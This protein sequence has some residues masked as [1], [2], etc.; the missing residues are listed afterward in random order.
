[1]KKSLNAF[2]LIFILLFLT[3]CTVEGNKHQSPPPHENEKVQTNGSAQS[4][5]TDYE[6]EENEPMDSPSKRYVL[7]YPNI[8][9]M[10]LSQFDLQ[11][12]YVAD[13]RQRAEDDFTE[14][15]NDIL[16][17]IKQNGFNTVF[18][19]I[20][21]YADSFYPSEYYPTSRYV[22]GSY[23]D[24]LSYDPIEITVKAAHAAELSIHGWINPMRGMTT[25]E[26]KS[27]SNKYLIKKWYDEKAPFISELNGRL[28][29]DPFYD[30]T[31]G[32]I[33]DGIKE[34][35]VKYKFD[36]IH[37]DDYFYPTTSESF[38]KAS[39]TAYKA[40]GG[41]APL[42]QFRYDNLNKLVSSIYSA[43]KE[44]SPDLLFGISPEGNMNNAT[45]KAF[46]DVKTWCSK[47]GFVDYICPR[48]YFGLEHQSWPFD[49]TADKW[50]S[51]I[52]NPE[53]K[54]I[55]G[56]TFGKALS[57]TDKWAGSGQNEWAEN[58]DVMKRCLEKTAENEKCAG[59]SV[60]CYQ[61]YYDPVSGAEVEGT[62]VERKAFTI[63]LKELQWTKKSLD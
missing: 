55:I 25:E 56:M 47:N 30:E 38:D 48:I 40:N 53:I 58:T 43:V 57:K 22:C 9:A 16:E 50:A 23:G 31:R 17:K 24:N 28:Y 29:L 62:A 33:V 7:N 15:I 21:P 14:R 19:Q 34:A 5:V 11:G 13:G 32:L 60:F 39:Y 63:L 42:K 10:W 3:G 54:L 59:V 4:E 52:K 51:I 37:M 45:D 20:R 46:A 27:V 41:T 61:Y 44:E 26:I 1:M 6:N 35:L 2:L 12:V 8:K 49:K 18:L 36:G